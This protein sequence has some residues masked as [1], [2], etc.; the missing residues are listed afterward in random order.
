MTDSDFSLRALYDAIDEQHRA[1]DMTWTAVHREINR[2]IIEGRPVAMSTITGLKSKP[3]GEGDGILQML[4]WLG[5]TPE[6]FV[7]DIQDA[8]AE[9]FRLPIPEEGKILRWNTRALHSALNTRT[10]G[11]GIDLERSRATNWQVYYCGH[12]NESGKRRTDRL[13]GSD[14]VCEM[15]G[16]ASGDVYSNREGERFEVQ[17]LDSG[18]KVRPS[19]RY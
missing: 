13:P 3:L 11:E 8:D 6:S 15:A 19:N 1:R 5:R 2:F 7:P 17:S 10:T 14:V 18:A 9:R 12:V 16:P 4:L